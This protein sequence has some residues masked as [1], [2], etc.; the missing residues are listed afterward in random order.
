VVDLDGRL[1]ASGRRALAAFLDDP[2][3]LPKR[4]QLSRPALHCLI[5]GA[6]CAV[7]VGGQGNDFFYA[8]VCVVP[9]FD[10][11]REIVI[12]ARHLPQKEQDENFVKC[13]GTGS[14]RG[15]RLRDTDDDPAET[16]VRGL[17]GLNAL[18]GHSFPQRRPSTTATQ[19][20]NTAALGPDLPLGDPAGGLGD[21]ARGKE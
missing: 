1:L 11:K 21:E 15:Y 8:G 3:L 19:Y 7:E 4:D 9:K 20:T 17:R 10:A 14:R 2:R 12:R 5:I 16:R 18:E 13:R 6:A